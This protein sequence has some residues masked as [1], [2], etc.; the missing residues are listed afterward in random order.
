MPHR[1]RIHCLGRISVQ[2]EGQTLAGAAAQ[3]RRLAILALLAYAGERGIP[4]DKLIGLLWTDTV[5]DRARRIISQ[6]LYML[7]RDLGSETVIQGLA[8]LRLNPE[9]IS[10]DIGDFRQ[11]IASRAYQQAVALYGGPLLDGFHLPGAPEFERWLEETRGAVAHDYAAA[12]ERCALEAE[13]RND[14]PGAASFWRQLA[15]QDPH[16]ARVALRLMRALAAAGDRPG[17]LRHAGV[18]EALVRTDLDLSPDAAVLAYA[19]EL[20]TAPAAA[21]PTAARPAPVATP[22]PPAVEATPPVVAMPDRPSRRRFW[23][24]RTLRWIVPS[25]VTATLTGAG[26]LALRP[27]GP[28]L[29]AGR[30]VVVPLENRAGDPLLDPVGQMAAEW[31]THGLARTGLV[32]VVDAQ[33][34]LE[35]VRSVAAPTA[36]P[37]LQTVA[38]QTRAGLVVSGAF[39]RDGDDLRF[40]AQITDGRSGEL[41]WSMDVV[42]APL[43]RPRDA[44][45]PLR[46]RITGGLAVLLD[47]RLNNWTAESSQP[48]TYEAYQEF[49]VGMEAFG[50]DFEEALRHFIRAASLDTSYWQAILWAGISYADLRRYPPADSLFQILNRNRGQLAPYDQANLDY[51]DGGFVHGDWERS[52]QG[53]RGMVQLAP[54]AGHALF[55]LGMTAIITNRPAEATRALRDIDTT[56]GWGKRWNTRIHNLLARA[57][58]QLGRHDVELGSARRMIVSEPNA[59]WARLQEIRALAALGRFDEAVGRAEQGAALPPAPTSWEPFLPGE[60]LYEAGRELRAHGSPPAAHRVLERAA[61]WYE[62]LPPAEARSRAQRVGLAAVQYALARYDAAAAIYGDL[63]A[64]DSSDVAALG[65]LGA[66]AV[67]QGRRTDAERFVGSLEQQ[68]RP[69]LFGAPRYAAAR[70]VA[71]EGDRERAVTLL[72]Q[73]RREGMARIYNFHLEQDFDSL[74]DY[75]PYR[76]LVRPRPATAR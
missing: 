29:D 67:R 9:E 47:D 55:A 3:R 48:P 71:L 51:F 37:S 15:A 70:I 41:Y 63:L 56:T 7:R 6:A 18:Y 19:G 27:S 1:L 46:Q 36:A 2:R 24:R 32:R 28:R 53:S 4:R 76:D 8:T 58:H 14:H 45:E 42:R 65:G 25:A 64:E 31:I 72:H 16:N 10:T 74:R 62:K 21:P 69:Y 50:T 52:Y 60:F 43:G 13:A 20:R 75:P 73:A 38:L 39:Y 57:N 44:L 34:M 30:V 17:A 22:T 68:R 40:Q 33:T 61:T 59:G 35:T 12:L 5:D 54:A 49:L 11:A 66:I 26:I 23:R